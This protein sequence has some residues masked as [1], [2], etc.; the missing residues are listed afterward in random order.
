MRF[1]R[2]RA[3]GNAATSLSYLAH[4]VAVE[5]LYV[6]TP[7]SVSSTKLLRDF[8]HEDINGEYFLR[9]AQ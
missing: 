8:I 3:Y 6:N 7:G 9:L 5:I 4:A 1:A 2:V